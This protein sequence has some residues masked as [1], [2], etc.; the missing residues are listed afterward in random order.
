V[1]FDYILW[2]AECKYEEGII[3]SINVLKSYLVIC[4]TKGIEPS[5]LGLK[6]YKEGV[7]VC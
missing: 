2:G 6:A 7:A 3:M 1:Q 5:F 4:A